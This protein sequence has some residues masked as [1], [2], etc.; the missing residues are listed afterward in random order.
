[1]KNTSIKLRKHIKAIKDVLERDGWC[2]NELQNTKGQRCLY[3]AMIVGE[4]SDSEFGRVRNLL[5][6]VAETESLLGWND[7]PKRNEKEVF[8]LLD[9]AYKMAGKK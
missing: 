5:I 6:E 8:A 2:K 3:G 1:M 9:E 7:A 4:M